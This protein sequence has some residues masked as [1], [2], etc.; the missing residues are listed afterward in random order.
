MSPIKEARDLSRQAQVA[1]RSGELRGALDLLARAMKLMAGHSAEPLYADLLR[2]SS[3]V[4]RE[5]G[6]VEEAE[7]V[8]AASLE[9]ARQH[10]HQKQGKGAENEQRAA[11]LA[12]GIPR[13]NEKRDDDEERDED[14]GKH[15]VSAF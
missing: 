11:L 12:R 9:I 14:G 13:H 10:G 6:D 3:T 2:W 5:L 1:R 4:Q 15:R 8:L 7:Q